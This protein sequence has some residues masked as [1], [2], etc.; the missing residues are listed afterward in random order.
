MEANRS[1]NLI[2]KPRVILND[3]FAFTKDLNIGDTGQI[4]LTGTKD[5][6]R[7]E[8]EA[9]DVER[10]VSTVKILDIKIITQKT[11]RT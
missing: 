11:K 8:L 6:E 2:K 9:D 5:A 1:L 7:M 3:K 10:I 4:E